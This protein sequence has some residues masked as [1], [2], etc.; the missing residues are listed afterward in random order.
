MARMG[1]SRHRDDVIRVTERSTSRP[2]GHA[3]AP[4]C[5]QMAIHRAS[6]CPLG[7]L[8]LVAVT[9]HKRTWRALHIAGCPTRVPRFARESRILWWRV[10]GCGSR[11]G[12]RKGRRQSRRPLFLVHPHPQPATRHVSTDS[13]TL[14]PSIRRWSRKPRVPV[15]LHTRSTESSCSPPA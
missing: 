10:E 14:S 2:A 7:K 4:S 12:I 8:A 6:V 1:V 13:P 9:R 3:S 11:V 15:E 5:E